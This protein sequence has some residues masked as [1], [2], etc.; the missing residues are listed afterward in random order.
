MDLLT[1][2]EELLLLAVWHL[3]EDAY[4]ASVRDYV[5]EK[6][7]EDWSIGSVYGP[8]DRLARRGYLRTFT[9]APTAERGGRSKRC[10]KLTSKA[11]AALNHAKQVHD[12]MWTGLP[13][14][15]LGTR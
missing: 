5:S 12:V 6:T 3:Q 9:G 8:L 2:S 10:F 1:R 13:R 14:L 15:N 7:G 4:G 11:V